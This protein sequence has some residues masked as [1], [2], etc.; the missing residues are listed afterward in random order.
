MT[1][2]WIFNNGIE[3][4][5][6]YFDNDL[7][8]F[9]VYLNNKYLGEIIPDSIESMQLCIDSLNLG[10]DPISGRWDDGM[11]NPCTINGW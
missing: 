2:E 6:E 3:V 10:E 4:H 1:K 5:K 7:C 9:D 11:G 8:K